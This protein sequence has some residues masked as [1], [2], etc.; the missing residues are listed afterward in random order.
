MEF[1]YKRLKSGQYR[2]I[3]PIELEYK[4]K[5]TRILSL[6]DSGADVCIFPSE[7]GEYLGIDI[8]S[9]K[10]VPV[11]GVVEG[12]KSSYYLHP[13]L[14]GVSG[15]GDKYSSQVGFMPNLSKQGYGILGQLGFF[16]NYKVILDLPNGKIYI[17]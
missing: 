8:E 1:E 15:G 6:V 9:G 5:K 17:S 16:E 4:D 2:P 10:E 14:L 11:Q 3:I 13:M 12:A 7:V